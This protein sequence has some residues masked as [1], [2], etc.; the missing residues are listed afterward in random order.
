MSA[1]RTE[2]T[3]LM[4]LPASDASAIDAAREQVR[5]EAELL[6]R[7]EP[8]VNEQM[9]SVAHR[10]ITRSG[11]VIPTGVG[12][13]GEIAR[14]MAHLLSVAGTPSLF[15]HPTDGLH[16]GLG[17][18]T[19]GDT[20]VAISKG[21]QSTELNEF[22]RRAR[23][24]GAFVIV[25]T[26]APGSPLAAL[27]EEVVEVPAPDSADPEGVIAMGSTLAVGAWGDAL[28]VMMKGL[29]GY[30]MKEVF[31]THPG[32]A[33]GQRAAREAAE[34]LRSPRRETEGDS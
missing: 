13:S 30:S 2:G 33:V 29:R 26:A 1:P 9:L 19:A 22:V 32:G 6:A 28:A 8:L 7:L 21:G 23:A 24:R 14:R 12:T 31:F 17:A 27:G 11:K 25:V 20:V 10:I 3:N 16:G 34:A 4:P 18:V 5:A 15:L